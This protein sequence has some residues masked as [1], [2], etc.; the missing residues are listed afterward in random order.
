MFVCNSQRV[1]VGAGIGNLIIRGGATSGLCVSHDGSPR[2]YDVESTAGCA[3][4]TGGA[5]GNAIADGASKGRVEGRVGQH[6]SNG[7]ELHDV[8]GS[9]RIN[10]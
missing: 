3:G 10:F 7:F 4:C 1:V 8:C 6:Q 5:R 2:R 9:E